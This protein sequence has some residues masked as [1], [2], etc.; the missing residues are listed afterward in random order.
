MTARRAPAFARSETDRAVAGVC[1]GLAQ[2][3]GVDATLVRLVFALLAL[4]GG[5]GV[6]LY[7]A[8]WTYGSRGNAWVA[9]VIAAV[10]VGLLLLA[11]GLSSGSV[12]GITLLVAG[13]VTVVVR[14]G[15]IRP[16]GSLPIPAVALVLAGALIFL[17]ADGRAT[18]LVAPG[19]LTGA[20][21]LIVGPWIWQLATER[22]ERIRLEERADVAARVHDSVLQTL[23]LVQ[24]HAA[25][26]TRVTALAR[27][28]ERDLRRW[29]YGGGPERTGGT[30][31]D[32]LG[33]AAGEIEEL[34]G[35]RIE[36]AASGDVPLDDKIEQL[37][38]AAR[39]AM[40]NAAK[41]SLAD[42]IAVFA[43]IDDDRI[44]VFIRDRGVGFD[45]ATVPAD[46]RGLSES[47]RRRM[48]RAGGNAAVT[49]EL[50]AGTEVEL[51]LP[52]R[53]A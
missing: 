43:D 19:A 49:T 2:T 7:L 25:D 21:V 38:L 29:L 39:E 50:G 36:L 27:R 14:G 46:R 45:P 12:L 4:A 24:R 10:S 35:G 48:G 52:K 17:G 44:A 31:V 26:P 23:A 32:A 34:H 22:T 11:L 20:L 30:L 37:V 18:P 28:Q 3:L 42:E 51:T 53:H 16:G 5:A 15:T 9:G 40:T 47:I 8:F 13:F 1:G 41:F 6:L 33:D